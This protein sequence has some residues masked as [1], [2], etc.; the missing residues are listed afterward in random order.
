MWNVEARCKVGREI[1]RVTYEEDDGT[2]ED[3]VAITGLHPVH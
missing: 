2:K 3:E 1:R